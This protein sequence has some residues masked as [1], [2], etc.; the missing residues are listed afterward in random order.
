[1][2]NEGQDQSGILETALQTVT[3]V[4]MSNGAEN[5]SESSEAFDEVMGDLDDDQMDTA[6]S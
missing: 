1:M 6:S 3:R 5:V 2:T 4:M